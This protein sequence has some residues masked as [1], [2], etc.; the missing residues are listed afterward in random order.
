MAKEEN[1][2]IEYVLWDGMRVS[3]VTTWISEAL[4]K[5][6]DEN[7]AIMRFGDRVE[8]TTPNGTLTAIKGDYIVKLENGELY[9]CNPILFASLNNNSDLRISEQKTNPKSDMEWISVEKELP[10]NLA[11]VIIFWEYQGTKRIT[12]GSY[13]ANSDYW[14]HGSATQLKVTHWM[15]LP[16]QP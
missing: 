4:N 10:V 6:F 16:T 11:T 12:S 8:I 14:Q 2:K 7:G 1:N 3:E 13:N 5:N 9:P 15:P